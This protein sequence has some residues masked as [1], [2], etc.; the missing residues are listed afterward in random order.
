MLAFFCYIDGVHTIIKM[1]T[2]FG[3]ELGLGAVG[4][5]AALVA[6]QLVAFPSALLFGRFAKRFSARTMLIVGT[7]AYTCITIYAALFLDTLVEF[8]IMAICVG[9]FQGGVQA[10]SRSYFGRLIPNKA[11]ANEY[12]GF[13]DIFG[14]YATIMGTA[15]LSF[16]TF[17]TGSASIGILSIGVLFVLGC[18]FLFLMPQDKQDSTSAR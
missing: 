3:T 16:F 8:W 7:I 17:A 11:H 6:T 14:K 13:F 4:L 1:A 5:V 9:L 10:L 15:L 12:Y 2:S 18:L